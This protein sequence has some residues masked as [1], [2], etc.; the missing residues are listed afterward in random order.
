[1]GMYGRIVVPINN[2]KL[3]QS[4]QSKLEGERS[5]PAG[6]WNL[7]RTPTRIGLFATVGFFIIKFLFTTNKISRV[8]DLIEYLWE[9]EELSAKIKTT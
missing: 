5:F 6:C 4:I 9:A 3:S 7:Q 2:L 8:E 1:M